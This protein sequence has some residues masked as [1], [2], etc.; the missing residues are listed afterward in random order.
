MIMLITPREVATKLEA[1]HASCEDSEYGRG[2][3]NI[4]QMA[5]NAIPD[6]WHRHGTLY[7]MQDVIAH[8]DHYVQCNGIDFATGQK[9]AALEVLA[10]FTVPEK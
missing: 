4:F 8:H 7:T 6:D 2:R 3:E 10:I 1:L 9:D 5:E